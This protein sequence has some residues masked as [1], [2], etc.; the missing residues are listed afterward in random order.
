MKS[1]AF[2]IGS[3]APL[4]KTDI[5][6]LTAPVIGLIAAITLST[7]AQAADSLAAG[8]PASSYSQ[9]WFWPGTDQTAESAFNGGGWN[10]GQWGRQWIQVDLLAPTSIDE[11][12][13]ITLQAPDGITAYGIYLSDSPIAGNWSQATPVATTSGFTAHLSPIDLRFMPTTARYLEIVADGGPSWTALAL[14]KVLPVPEPASW[15]LMTVG[16]MLAAIARIQK[17]GFAR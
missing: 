3:I 8:L 12:S 10:A 4:W 7:A 17:T 1:N 2:A 13:F 5:N 11:V 9:S 6:K 16:L 15:V 14:V